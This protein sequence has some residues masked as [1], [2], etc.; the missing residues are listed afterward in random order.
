[1]WNGIILEVVFA[2]PYSLVQD[3]ENTFFDFLENFWIENLR[4]IGIWIL[5]VTAMSLMTLEWNS[6]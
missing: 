6:R 5:A 4:D 1:M 3:D 2:S